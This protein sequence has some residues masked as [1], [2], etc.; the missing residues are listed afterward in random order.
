MRVY[1]TNTYSGQ[2]RIALNDSQYRF[3]NRYSGIGAAQ[4]RNTGIGKGGRRAVLD[5]LLDS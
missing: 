4:Y 2:G 3:Q 1:K 5:S